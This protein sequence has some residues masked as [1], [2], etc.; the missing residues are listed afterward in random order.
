MD[1]IVDHVSIKLYPNIIDLNKN[2][3]FSDLLNPEKS[4]HVFEPTI[5]RKCLPTRCKYFNAKETMS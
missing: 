3:F 2:F 1:T 4:N 5:I